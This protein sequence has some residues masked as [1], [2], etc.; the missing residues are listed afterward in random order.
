MVPLLF[1][2]LLLC[3]LM[4]VCVEGHRNTGSYVYYGLRSDCSGIFLGDGEGLPRGQVTVT[5]ECEALR[6][7]CVF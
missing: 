6:S 5:C 3:T 4:G 2:C 7:I 1:R